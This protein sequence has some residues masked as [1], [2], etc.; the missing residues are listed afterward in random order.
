MEMFTFD[1][2]GAFGVN[3][4]AVVSEKKN[5]VL[6]DAPCNADGIIGMMKENGFM[7][8]KI[9]LTHGHFDHIGAAE[10]L[11]EKTGCEVYIHSNDAS[12]LSNQT[13]NLSAFFR[14]PPVDPVEGYKTLSHNDIIE[15]D[16]L[17]FRVMLTAGHSSGSV[18]YIIDDIIFSGDT[19]FRLSAGRT[20]MRDGNFQALKNSLSMLAELNDKPDYVVFPGHGEP[21]RLSYEK[22]NNQF[23]QENSDYDGML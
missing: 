18:C 7:L 9:L 10:E 4:Y 3:C 23:M 15:Q 12:K 8:K 21:T 17:K 16:E 19:L 2:M 22:E 14:M 20:D 11:R 1:N 13:M 5:A 6:I